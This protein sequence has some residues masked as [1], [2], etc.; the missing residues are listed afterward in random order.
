MTTTVLA[1]PTVPPP[2]PA[3]G[4]RQARSAAVLMLI[5]L[6]AFAVIAMW[7]H[8]TPSLG[9]A[10]A[11]LTNAGR[12]TGLLAGY[13]L[14]VLLV[15]MSRAPFLDRGLG[16]DTVTRWHAHGGRY[17]VGLIVA[18]AVLIT[19]GY[20]MTAHTNVVN[21]THTLLS[22]YPDVLMATV[23]GLLFVAIG[24]VSARAARARMRYETWY[25]LHLFTYLAIALGFSHQFSTGA[26]FVNNPAARAAWSAMYIAAASLVIWYRLVAPIRAATLHHLRV[27]DVQRESA[28]TV[29]ITIGGDWLEELDAE[30]GQFFR[31]RFLTRNDWWQSHPYSLSA[32]PD[33]RSL[34]IT[35]KD[36]GDHSRDLQR[37]RVGTRVLAEG[38]YGAMTARQRRRRKVLLVAGGV[39]ITPLRALFESLPARPGELTL[40]VR[41]NR[42][43]EIVFREELNT[44]AQRRGAAVHYLVGPP[45]SA[46]DPFV[47][48]RLQRIVPD[49]DRHDVFLC[50]PPRFMTAAAAC[51]RACGVPARCLHREHFAF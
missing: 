48:T 27:I 28:D 36:L 46:V 45:G 34:R 40:I 4:N 39:G 24:I 13:T 32:P 10:G 20:A 14:A 44:I 49:I 8:D 51:I 6:G 9:G 21:E 50:G 43:E 41:A 19:W 11:W 1:P 26:D 3:R 2:A 17:V 12:I 7:W 29:S 16:T 25:Y 31:W 15:L 30:S 22:S 23:A 33:W 5:G 38:P 47:G 42:T 35:V 37:V 18:H